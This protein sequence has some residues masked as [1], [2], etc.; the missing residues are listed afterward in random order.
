[1]SSIVI[2]GLLRTGEEA[3]QIGMLCHDG[4]H[5]RRAASVGANHEDRRKIPP[6]PLQ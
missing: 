2:S 5:N 3:F 4:T 1:M 6:Q